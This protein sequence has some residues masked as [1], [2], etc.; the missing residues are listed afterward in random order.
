MLEFPGVFTLPF[1]PEGWTATSEGNLLELQP[2]THDA[3]A[4]ISVYQRAATQLE[5]GQA[6]GFL[7]TFV[8][9]EP[10]EGTVDLRVL[11]QNGDEQRA[12][13]KY[14]NRSADGVVTEW[15]AGCILWPTAMLICSC[16]APPGNPALKE[17]EMMIASIFQ[18]TE[19]G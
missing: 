11:P 17:G 12:F 10:P 5:P 16:N 8:Y 1:V 15:F 14:Q 2:P 7:K 18:G 13:A 4:H 19:P 6:E 9:R 3:A